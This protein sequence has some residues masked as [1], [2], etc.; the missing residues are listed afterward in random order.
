MVHAVLTDLLVHSIRALF[1]VPLD[2]QTDTV[3]HSLPNV[4]DVLNR[5][6]REGQSVHLVFGRNYVGVDQID[7]AANGNGGVLAVLSMEEHIDIAIFQIG[8]L[9]IK[10]RFATPRPRIHSLVNNPRCDP[11]FLCITSKR[12]FLPHQT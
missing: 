2:P 7:H 11:L 1:P 12:P 3:I 8:Q 5:R 9:N 6:H 4:L 10:Y